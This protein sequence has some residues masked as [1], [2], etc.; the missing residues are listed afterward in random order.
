MK[1]QTGF[2][3]VALMA[4]STMTT[5]FAQGTGAD[6]YKAKCAMCHA[7]DGSASGPAGKAMKVPP[8]SASKMSEAEMIAETKAGKGKMPAFAGK[9]TDG[10][11]KDV[12]TYI[13]T[14]K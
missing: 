7:A 13:K 4:A 8:F 1:I 14:L 5:A 6:N 11:I 3:L 2:A 9:L 12:V 10:Q